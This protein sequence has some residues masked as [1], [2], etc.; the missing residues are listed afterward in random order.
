MTTE[1]KFP[2]T[3]HLT[4]LGEESPRT[5]KV[6]SPD[7]RASFLRHP[8]VV[9]EKIDGA[10]VGISFGSSLGPVV[11]NRGTIL[12]A[13]SHPQ[14]RALWPW[15]AARQF[16]L[17][18]A[19]RERLV[20]FGEWCFA[21][22]S[23]HYDRLPDYFLTIDVYDTLTRRFWSA[24]RRDEWARN[25]GL[26]IVPR[27]AVGKFTVEDLRRLL[28]STMSRFGSEPVEGLYL[29]QEERGWL[30]RRAKLVRPEFI[31]GINEHWTDRQL[32]INMVRA[33]S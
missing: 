32:E 24:D 14:F 30:Q 33:S 2:R 10:N 21:V 27:L 31:Q 13:G 16:E 6:F 15:L 7:E 26:A 28:I 12:K 11:R 29:R 18:E 20:L 4:W 19:L 5:D 1:Y 3:S 9:E 17:A 22:H 25:N 23:V 8:L